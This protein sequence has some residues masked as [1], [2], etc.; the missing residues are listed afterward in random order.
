MAKAGTKVR[1]NRVCVVVTIVVVAAAVAM[2]MGTPSDTMSSTI[3]EKVCAVVRYEQQRVTTP[4]CTRIQVKV[5][6]SVLYHRRRPGRHQAREG[7][8][9]VPVGSEARCFAVNASVDRRRRWWW[10][11]R[12]RDRQLLETKL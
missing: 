12:W 10:R 1:V 9:D 7:R 11:R 6:V 3:E 5:C 2:R 4:G 8:R